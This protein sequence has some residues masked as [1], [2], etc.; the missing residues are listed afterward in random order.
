MQSSRNDSKIT[1]TATLPPDNS[2]M[3]WKGYPRSTVV[4]ILYCYV[5][6]RRVVIGQL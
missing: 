6:K 2:M 3:N 1:L 4:Q 5:G